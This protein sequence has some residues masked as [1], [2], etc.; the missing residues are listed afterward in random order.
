MSAIELIYCNHE[1]NKLEQQWDNEI[2]A[3]KNSHLNLEKKGMR[4][5][6][7]KSSFL[8]CVDLKHN[9]YISTFIISPVI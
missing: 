6:K 9:T 1:I 7:P 3:N 2:E 8:A 4:A 5:R